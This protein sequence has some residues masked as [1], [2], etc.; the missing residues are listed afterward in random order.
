MFFAV[1]IARILCVMYLAA[2]VGLFMNRAYFRLI[3]DDLFAH[4]SLI[5]LGGFVSLVFGMVIVNKHNVWVADWVGLVTIVGWLA[6]LKGIVLIAFPRSM[7][8]YANVVASKAM[9]KIGPV[10]LLALGLVFGYFGFVY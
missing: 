10:V 6:T 7:Q 5:Y 9:M 4:P 2:A 1:L 3:K 8:R